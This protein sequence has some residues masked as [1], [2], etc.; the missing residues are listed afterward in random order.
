M[1]KS[2]DIARGLRKFR[3]GTREFA[4]EGHFFSS[5]LNAAAGHTRSCGSQVCK[6]TIAAP[7]SVASIAA[8]AILLRGHGPIRRRA[9]RV[10]RIRDGAGDDDLSLLRG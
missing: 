7:A 8:F 2:P 6:W 9:G 3:L 5:L 4:F 10:D 1:Q